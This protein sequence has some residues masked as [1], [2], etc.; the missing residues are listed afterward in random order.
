MIG[1]RVV[2]GVGV[3]P[4]RPHPTQGFP[5]Q[6]L[7]LVHVR[8]RATPGTRR[9]DEMTADIAD[10]AE[11]GVTM[12]ND[13]FPGAGDAVSPPHEVRTGATGFQAGGVGATRFELA[14][15]WSRISAL[16]RQRHAPKADPRFYCMQL[17]GGNVGCQ[18][19]SWHTQS[20]NVP[21]RPDF[22]ARRDRRE[23]ARRWRGRGWPSPAAPR[24][25]FC[26]A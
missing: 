5:D 21:T 22:P 6:G 9:H 17:G 20:V 23:S 4:G 7:K 19:S 2:P 15:S 12:I 24:R 1:F 11:L 8:P 3:D 25:L 16:A 13:G 10:Q 14:T 18:R 26:R